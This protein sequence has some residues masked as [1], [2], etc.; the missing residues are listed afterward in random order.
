MHVIPTLFLTSTHF[1][2]NQA[3]LTKLKTEFP[4]LQLNIVQGSN[5][6]RE[7]LQ[8][9]QIIVGN[10]KAEDL[11]YATNLRWLPS[12]MAEPGIRPVVSPTS[13]RSAGPRAPLAA[14]YMFSTLVS[15]S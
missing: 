14:S 7:Q 11:K 4:Q 3:E 8:E 2:P 10:P 1:C 9:A 12:T 15:T 6:T 13:V 5:Y